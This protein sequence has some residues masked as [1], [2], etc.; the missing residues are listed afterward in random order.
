MEEKVPELRE[1]KPILDRKLNE[2]LRLGEQLGDFGIELE[3][4]GVHLPR[5]CQG[6]SVKREG[7]LRG[8]G[9]RAVYGDEDLFDTPQ[10]YVLTKPRNYDELER[11]L[12]RLTGKFDIGECKVSLTTR[13][14]THVHVNMQ[15]QTLKTLFGFMMLFTIIEPVLL[16]LCGKER[17]GNLFCLPT[18]E[19]GDLPIY[20]KNLVDHIEMGPR[21][22]PK[23]QEKY[24]A[25]NVSPI[26][27]FG[28]VEVRCFP[29]TID[30]PTIVKW[31]KW[32]QNIRNLA[33]SMD[34]PEYAPCLDHCYNDPAWILK[35]VFEDTPV[36]SDCY[37]TNPSEL[38]A[39]G[40]ENAF[41]IYKAM[42]PLWE[43]K[44]KV[45][46]KK[47]V[48]SYLNLVNLEHAIPTP[49]EDGPAYW[50]PEEP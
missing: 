7:S 47:R 9:G 45:K 14:S 44:E 31:C 39:F 46:K 29:N 15:H 32:L 5:S 6:W 11:F 28:S 22:W 33:A 18:Y 20:I 27:T 21:Y 36:F 17:N 34:T 37:P 40:V 3:I 35:Q 48:P 10:E 25:L 30:V 38:I 4:E 26:M 42:K 8:I 49:I 12:S 19:S 13:A 41:E 2:I 1:H 43:R 16:R 23:R 50:G 24:A